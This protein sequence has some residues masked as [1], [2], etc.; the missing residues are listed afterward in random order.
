M[1]NLLILLLALLSIGVVAL[2][3]QPNG[4]ITEV[5][6][7]DDIPCYE[8]GF[9]TARCVWMNFELGKPCDPQ[10]ECSWETWKK[11]TFGANRNKQFEQGMNDFLAVK[12][13]RDGQ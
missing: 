11:C 5:A 12:P 3:Q 7:C 9:R 1:K 2:A 4:E 10:D 6:G 13:T 8:V